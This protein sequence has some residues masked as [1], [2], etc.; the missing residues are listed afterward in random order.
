MLA[1]S[2][3]R[4]ALISEMQ[5]PQSTPLENEKRYYDEWPAMQNKNS[6]SRYASTT[7]NTVQGPTAYIIMLALASA[8]VR[9]NCILVSQVTLS[10][11]L[12]IIYHT[13]IHDGQLLPCSHCEIRNMKEKL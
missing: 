5:W 13:V 10:P 12:T 1:Y 8:E 9:T 3:Q 6:C 7:R 4:I 11:D 2:L